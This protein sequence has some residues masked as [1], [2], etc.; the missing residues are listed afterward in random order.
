MNV[1]PEQ[2]TKLESAWN[3]LLI[4]GELVPAIQAV[5]VILTDG[6]TVVVLVFITIV[7]VEEL[8]DTLLVVEPGFINHNH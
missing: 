8:E 6:T 2:N 3:S 4:E 7:E 1:F 5:E